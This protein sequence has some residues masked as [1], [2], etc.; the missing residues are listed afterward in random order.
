MLTD[1]PMKAITLAELANDYGDDSGA[2]FDSRVLRLLAE[3]A[4][5]KARAAELERECGQH[6]ATRAAL[7]QLGPYATHA[8]LML[9]DELC[10]AL[11]GVDKY[12]K[13]TLLAALVHH[14]EQTERLV[15][16]AAKAAMRDVRKHDARAAK[17]RATG[18]EEGR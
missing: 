14:R 16:D 10:H 11:R 6:E 18:G 17:E 4:A 1:G 5:F 8:D 12:D 2:M 7:H 9:L 15:K 3:H 13:R